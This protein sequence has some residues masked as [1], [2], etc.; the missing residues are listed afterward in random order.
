MQMGVD[1]EGSGDTGPLA[2]KDYCR[3]IAEKQ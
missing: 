2:V 3:K 1:L